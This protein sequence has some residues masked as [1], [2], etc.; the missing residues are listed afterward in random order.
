MD[1]CKYSADMPL[2]QK[3]E[4]GYAN[5]AKMVDNIIVTPSKKDGSKRVVADI[6]FTDGTKVIKNYRSHFHMETDINAWHYYPVVQMVDGH[7]MVIK[8]TE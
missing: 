4:E 3:N 1:N 2:L 5:V 7:V 8:Y 6:R